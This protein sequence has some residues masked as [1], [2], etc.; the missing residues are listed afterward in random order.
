MLKSNL[1]R[2][3]HNHGLMMIICC[4]IPIV[5]ILTL[6]YLGS[7]GSWGYYALFLICPLG[8]IVMLRR[9]HSKSKENMV[10]GQIEQKVNDS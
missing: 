7:L 8:H 6:S 4:G 9:M 3:E 10:P 1:A 2:I 5:G